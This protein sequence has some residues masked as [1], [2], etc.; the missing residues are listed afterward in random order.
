M[1][2][3]FSLPPIFPVSHHA[4]SNETISHNK[5]LSYA[6]S[7]CLTVLLLGRAADVSWLFL[8]SQSVTVALWCS[9]RRP[10][11]H[12]P[13]DMHTVHIYSHLWRTA[14]VTV[15][16]LSVFSE[17]IMRVIIDSEEIGHLRGDDT[18]DEQHDA[19]FIPKDLILYWCLTYFTLL[20][21][22]YFCFW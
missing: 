19:Y 1:T 4:L 9:R 22:V 6:S 10:L 20:F 7:L 21:L 11:L 18:A 14:S 15:I 12:K 8:K 17:V 16:V 13:R 2:L 5:R 3:P